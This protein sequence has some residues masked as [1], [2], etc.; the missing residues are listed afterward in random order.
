M[1]GYRLVFPCLHDLHLFWKLPSFIP[2]LFHLFASHFKG[3]CHDYRLGSRQRRCRKIEVQSEG[4]G[5]LRVNTPSKQH[6][7]LLQSTRAPLVYWQRVTIVS[8]GPSLSLVRIYGCWARQYQVKC[9]VKLN[10]CCTLFTVVLVQI[11]TP[12]PHTHT[13]EWPHRN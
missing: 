7:F 13:A 8:V 10:I 3:C 9:Q 11:Y 5:T 2:I 12:P 1:R 4:R 6:R